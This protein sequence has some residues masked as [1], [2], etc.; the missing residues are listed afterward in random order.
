[1][2]Q[3]N[4]SRNVVASA[5][6]LTWLATSG[7]PA[8]ADATRKFSKHDAGAT[9]VVDHAVWD[10]LIKAYVVPGKDGLNRVRYQAFKDS[11]HRKLKS[12]IKMLTG[13]RPTSL[14]R[15]EQ[16]AYWANLYNAKTI[17]VV[18]DAYP[19]KSIREISIKGGLLGFLKKSVGKGGPWKA[20]IMKVEGESLSLDDVEHGIL[21]PIFKDPRVHYAVNCASVGCPNLQLS[22][23]TGAKLEVMLNAGA[24]AYVNSPRGFVRKGGEITA[25]SIYNWFASDFGGNARGVLRHAA[26]YA[27]PQ[28]AKKLSSAASITGYEYD[29]SLNDAK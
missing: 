11:G 25:S 3:S 9:T 13:I 1:M 23:F 10:K 2:A 12:Y 29:W 16:F 7:M 28:L 4:I 24:K 6:A 22:A 27:E 5:L 26:K 21:R 15:P 19:V 8:A 14:A 18:L 17:D 20:K